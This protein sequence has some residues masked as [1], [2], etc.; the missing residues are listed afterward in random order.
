M[1]KLLLS[2]LS[3]TFCLTMALGLFA[4]NGKNNGNTSGNGSSAS[5]GGTKPG[6]TAEENFD[7]WLTGIKAAHLCN[8]NYTYTFTGTRS[9]TD[10][11][12]TANYLSQEKEA[13]SGNKYFHYANEYFVE[14]DESLSEKYKEI[15][16]IKVVDDNGTARNKRYRYMQNFEPNFE[17]VQKHGYYVAPDEAAE[18][19]EYTP[20]EF[21]AEIGFD[22]TKNYEE[23][24]AAFKKIWYGEEKEDSGDL[25]F[26]LTR[27][28]DESV[29]FTA[30]GEYTVQD[31]DL[32]GSSYTLNKTET[33]KYTVKGGKFVNYSV[34]ENGEYDYGDEEQNYTTASDFSSDYTYDDFDEAYYNSI[35]MTTDGTYHEYVGYINFYING[36][37]Y[38]SSMRVPVGE[39]AT[40][41]E[42]KKYFTDWNTHCNYNTLIRKES[43][44]DEAY[45]SVSE[46]TKQEWIAESKAENAKF[47]AAMQLFTD[48]EMTKPFSSLTVNEGDE[49]F[50]VY[51]K[52]TPPDDDA[53]VL[54]VIPSHSE[55]RKGQLFVR[56]IQSSA[57]KQDGTLYYNANNR[58]S[59]YPVE[60][61]D[62]EA[63]AED[64]I[65]YFAGGSIHIFVCQNNYA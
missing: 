4:C 46:E 14:E 21:I 56:Y 65:Y 34:L 38:N 1:K 45:D 6:Y 26:S 29:T 19:I 22:K 8:D 50:T 48:A 23:A 51:V 42:V 55:Y 30:K 13:R 60:S 28:K 24:C 10:A 18:Q 54:C 15:T 12:G 63:P 53:W 41:D 59:G 17:D 2:L 43:Y 31:T 47:M 44:D 9:Y 64:G 25:T 20:S 11:D 36:Y 7:Y 5:G 16:A 40:A 27:N 35:D 62:G 32:Q 49:K 52:L 58:L 57:H 3:F 61:V 37:L 33:Y 39:S